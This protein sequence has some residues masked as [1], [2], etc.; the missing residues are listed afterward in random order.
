MKLSWMKIL[1]IAISI[2]GTAIVIFSLCNLFVIGTLFGVAFW[3]LGILTLFIERCF[4]NKFRE[5]KQ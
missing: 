2:F 3:V 4:P 1:G 5:V